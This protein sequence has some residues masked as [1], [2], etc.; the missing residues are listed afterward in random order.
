M[1]TKDEDIVVII[2]KVVYSRTTNRNTSFNELINE[3]FLYIHNEKAKL[4]GLTPALERAYISTLAKTAIAIF[5]RDYNVVR[6]PKTQYNTDR[7]KIYDNDI[8]TSENNTSSNKLEDEYLDNCE[9]LTVI[10]KIYNKDNTK[11]VKDAIIKAI[12]NLSDIETNIIESRWFADKEDIK[13]LKE[14]AD[15][16]NSTTSG[17]HYIEKNALEKLRYYLRALKKEFKE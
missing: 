14:L 8:T 12:H 15:E 16:L 13:T 1:H 2:K 4:E 9:Q 5:Y 3:A 17:I 11:L 10:D 6:L 7:F